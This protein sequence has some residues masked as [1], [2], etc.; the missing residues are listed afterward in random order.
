MSFSINFINKT[1]LPVNIETFKQII[2]GYSTLTSN[3]INPNIE[4]KL[5][6]STGEWYINTFS[7]DE[8]FLKMW[9]DKNLHYINNIGKF[10]NTFDNNYNW[11]IDEKM[12]NIKYENNAIILYLNI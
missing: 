8:E 2:Y 11:I 10:Y 6:S 9:K 5:Y 12:F 7:H 1:C 4:M 3:I